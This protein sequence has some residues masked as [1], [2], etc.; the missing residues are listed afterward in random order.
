MT[1]PLHPLTPK[2]LE[3]ADAALKIIGTKGI[4]A[5]TTA[6]LA[7]ELGVSPGAP[8][9]HFA[10]REEILEAVALRVEELVLETIPDCDCAPLE[11]IRLLFRARARAV[12]RHAGIARLMFSEQFTLA[13]PKPAAN[14]LRGLVTRTRDFLLD[15]LAEA[16]ERG[17][18]RSD[19][20][21]GTLLPVVL[22]SLQ[23]L[24]FARSLGLAQ[25][26]E[27]DVLADTVIRL[28]TPCS[29]PH[30]T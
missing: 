16:L 7:A 13:L 4:A 8:F 17:E 9:R 20:P 28:L 19:I 11:R 30:L 2:R 1:T 29:L 3:I 25:E 6:T 26:A 21:P 12:G 10:N 27:A 5:L 15:A 24:I 22:G 14:R 23:H 18:I